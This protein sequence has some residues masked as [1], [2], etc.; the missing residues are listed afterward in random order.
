MAPVVMLG[1]CAAALTASNGGEPALHR[2]AADVLAVFSILLGLVLIAVLVALLYAVYRELKRDTVFLDPIDVP[3]QLAD[4]GYTGTYVAERLVDELLAL[5]RNSKTMR[6]GREID[7][8]ASLVDLTIPGRF[9]MQAILRYAHRILRITEAHISG[10]I[11][12][13]AHG[14]QL[15]LRLRNQ[16]VAAIIGTHLSDDVGTLLRFGAD[17]IMG[18][19]DPHLVAVRHY[20]REI[21]GPY[22]K[23][24]AAIRAIVD[25]PRSRDRG[26]ALKLWGDCLLDQNRREEA[27]AKYRE[28]IATDLDVL[29]AYLSLAALLR[30]MGLRVQAEGILQELLDRQGRTSDC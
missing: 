20:E 17:D 22:E 9:S 29:P 14:F 4:R 25:Q 27:V 30:A 3:R 2:L 12:E 19:V 13:E 7:S 15:I 11:T 16:R 8:T 5:Q 23:T 21:G 6:R 1:G 24:L 10:G 18:V 26:W 28:A